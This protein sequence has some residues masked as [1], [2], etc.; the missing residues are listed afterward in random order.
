MFAQRRGGRHAQ[1]VVQPLRPAEP[2]HLG[3]AVVA[4]AAQ[5]DLDPGPIATDGGDQAVQPAHDL[6]AR[7]PAGRAQHGGDHAPGL[8]EHDD[9]LEAVFVMVGVEQAQLLAAMHGVEGV[10]DV[11]HDAARNLVEA[12]AIMIDHGAAHMQQGTQ[13]RQVLETRDG[14]LRAQVGAT[15]EPVHRQLEHRITAQ[16]V[17]VV[18]VLV[19]GGDHQHAR[20][21]DLVQAMDY[22]V[23][24]TRVADAGRQACRNPE[25]PLDL[26]ERQ[27]PTIR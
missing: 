6:L 14:R 24:R 21:N 27:K 1:R 23:R 26:A 18:A 25:P 12:V 11:Q 4:V 2:Q 7:R 16:G 13:V 19:T 22:P 5:H 9:R 10:V 3:R 20:A 15:R 8:V 17:G